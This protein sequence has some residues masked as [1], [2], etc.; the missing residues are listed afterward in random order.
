MFPIPKQ[1][2][3]GITVFGKMSMH[4]SV[5]TPTFVRLATEPRAG[6][7]ALTLSEP[8]SGWQMG[9]RLILPDTRHMKNGEV[10]PTRW[11]NT[12][13]PVGRADRSGRFLQTAE[14]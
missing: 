4:G 9:D 6:H 10:D 11:L 2:G 12:R 14:P 5:R 13:Q 3:T 1:F 8:V 7:T